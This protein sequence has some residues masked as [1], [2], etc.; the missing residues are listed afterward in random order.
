MLAASCWVWWHA[1]RWP[2]RVAATRWGRIRTAGVEGLVCGSVWSGIEVGVQHTL[3]S[4]AMFNGLLAGCAWAGTAWWTR[5]R[6]VATWQQGWQHTPPPPVPVTSHV[7]QQHNGKATRHHLQDTTLI[8]AAGAPIRT[9]P[10]LRYGTSRADANGIHWPRRISYATIALLSGA[11][12]LLFW[13]LLDD[14]PAPAWSRTALGLQLLAG[15]LAVLLLT[16]WRVSLRAI[17]YPLLL[18]VVIYLWD[19]TLP[20]PT[21][22]GGVVRDYVPR[23]VVVG[24]LIDLVMTVRH[25]P[26]TPPQT[27]QIRAGLV[28]IEHAAALLGITVDEVR[29]RLQ[30]TG[31]TA[32]RLPDGNDVLSLD[33]VRAITREEGPWNPW[34]L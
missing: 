19:T 29:R 13:A 8:H 3:T 26:A 16:R 23:V 24:L 11:G 5:E 32:L 27:V 7:R 22:P 18:A 31:R 28:S 4:E 9:A 34:N 33:D 10:V 1:L 15:S 2:E 20:P 12:T 6:F 25:R 17:S 14:L 21:L 30:Q